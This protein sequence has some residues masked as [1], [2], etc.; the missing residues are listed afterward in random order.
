MKQKG[1]AS[2]EF[3]QAFALFFIIII[4]FSAVF[5]QKTAAVSR[6][7]DFSQMFHFV[8]EISNDI[9]MI[10]M[11]GNGASITITLPE[12]VQGQ[13]YTLVLAHSAKA[14][15]AQTAD[16]NYY[17]SAFITTSNVNVVQ[18]NY[19]ETQT[20]ENVNGMVIIK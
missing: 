20:I 1:Q 2:F 6:Q 10:D 13:N 9:N 12:Q 18:W 15:E 16:K 7:R 17:A 11:A 5:V 4:V 19:G 8:D 3:M 14:L